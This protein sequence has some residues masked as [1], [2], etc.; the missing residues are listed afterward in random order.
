MHP[1]IERALL[2][3]LQGQKL[4]R[5]R[6]QVLTSDYQEL[7]L[8]TRDEESDGPIE[9]QFE[10][11]TVIHISPDTEQMSVNV[12]PGEM[13]QWG[14]HY[15]LIDPSLNAF[16]GNI[17]GKKIARINALI[18]DHASSTYPSEFAIEVI[19][20]DGTQ[21]STEYISDEEH[22]DALR[23]TERCKEPYRRNPLC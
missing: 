18:S 13:P 14:E 4:V 7:P 6:R 22:T 11:G 21:F 12:L 10:N 15:E 20:E 5:V 16:W 3:N 23:V 17:L 2:A 9:L 8:E 1:S 19:M